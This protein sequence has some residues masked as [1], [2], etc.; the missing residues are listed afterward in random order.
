MSACPVSFLAYWSSRSAMQVRRNGNIPP[1]L[2]VD[3]AFRKGVRT[4]PHEGDPAVFPFEFFQ[5][6]RR[7]AHGGTAEKVVEMGRIGRAGDGSDPGGLGQEPGDGELGHGALLALGPA[8]DQAGQ[9]HVVLQGFR[10][11]L[12]QGGQAPCGKAAVLVDGAGQEA[13]SQRAV[14]D[15]ADA[16]FPQGGEDLG[17]R[18]APQKG[19]FALH[20]ADG[21]D[22]MARRME[23]ALASDRPK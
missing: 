6:L 5:L 3:L 17:L 2:F 21:L 14:R 4:M 11:E 22:G 18:F 20:G 1:G 12:R 23:A 10:G 9:G 13:P 8:T 19:V 7:Q 16:Q 15:K